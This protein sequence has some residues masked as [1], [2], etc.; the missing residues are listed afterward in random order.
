MTATPN[1]EALFVSG[2]PDVIAIKVTDTDSNIFFE[3]VSDGA[4]SFAESSGTYELTA[5][6]EPGRR[7]YQRSDSR[8]WPRGAARG[9]SGR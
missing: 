1:P 6:P 8:E 2:A 7:F 4:W 5:V 9:R 3:I